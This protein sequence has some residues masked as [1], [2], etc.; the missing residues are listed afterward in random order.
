MRIRKYVQYF[1]IFRVRKI[2]NLFISIILCVIENE[3][4]VF[5]H[6][7]RY[8]S[9][10][11][12]TILKERKKIISL[13]YIYIYGRKRDIFVCV[14]VCMYIQGIPDHPYTPFKMKINGFYQKS[15][16]IFK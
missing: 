11:R 15:R 7:N 5:S 16:T 13:K 4:S 14:Y 9:L 2:S 6:E 1:L 12:D 10:M 8:F 3:K